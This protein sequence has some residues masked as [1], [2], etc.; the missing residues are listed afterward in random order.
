[1]KRVV[2]YK[3]VN[4]EQECEICGRQPA[5]I[6]VV[7]IWEDGL[8]YVAGYNMLE[9]HFCSLRCAKEGYPNAEFVHVRE[10]TIEEINRLGY[11][12]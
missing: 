12:A 5:K 2:F 3:R 7:R 4:K 6:L 9:D 1:M 8:S 11:M 10:N